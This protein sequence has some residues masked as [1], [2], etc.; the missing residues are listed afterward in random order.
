MVYAVETRAE[1]SRKHLLRITEV[2]IS[3]CINDDIPRDR[4]RNED[5]RDICEIQD[6]KDIVREAKV[7]RRT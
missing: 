5:I 3:R 7:R 2:R 4:I 1:T 6:I